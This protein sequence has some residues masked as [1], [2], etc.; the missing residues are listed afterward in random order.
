MKQ[1]AIRLIQSAEFHKL[2][3]HIDVRYQL[4]REKYEE[5]ILKY[6]HTYLCILIIKI[7]FEK[8]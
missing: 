1:S 2:S 6:I 4:I 7:M 3:K 8:V 5:K